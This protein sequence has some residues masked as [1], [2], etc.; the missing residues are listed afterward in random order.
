MLPTFGSLIRGRLKALRLSQRDLGALVGLTHESINRILTEKQGVPLEQADAWADALRF[1]DAERDLFLDLMHL[2]ASPPRVRAMYAREREARLTA[3][4][5]RSECT[6]RIRRARQILDLMDPQGRG[7][8]PD[9]MSR[10]VDE[11]LAAVR[12]AGEAARVA[13]GGAPAAPAAP[14]TTDDAELADGDDEPDA[15]DG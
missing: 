1:H 13:E 3:E 5:F 7:A 12:D 15:G 14:A 6:H 8:L 2:A 11:D 9:E 4:M 10:L